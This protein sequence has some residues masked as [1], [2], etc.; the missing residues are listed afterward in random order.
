MKNLKP[1]LIEI[2]PGKKELSIDSF[3][4]YLRQN[5]VSLSKKWALSATG[6]SKGYN[7]IEIDDLTHSASKA[8]DA[9]LEIL[10]NN[11]FKPMSDYIEWL[12]RRRKHQG[13]TFTEIQQAFSNLRY[14]LSPIITNFY[15]QNPI[16]LTQVLDRV[17]KVIDLT[18]FRFSEYFQKSH[19]RELKKHANK[20]E[21][22]VKQRTKEL[23]ES[24][25]NYQILFEEISDGCFVN[26]DGRIVFANKAFCEMHGYKREELIGKMC[27]DLIAEDSREKV[28]AHF[29]KQLKG[30]LTEERY[31]YCRQSKKGDRFPTEN[32]VKL[33]EYN[34][35]P[36]V[37]GLCSDITQRLEMEEKIKQK[38]RL[39]L[40]GR[41]T[42]SI[43]H[44]IRNPLSAI[45]VNIQILLDKLK[46]EGNDLRR[47]QIASEQLIN[48]ENIITQVLDFAKP[49]KLN[50]SLCKIDELVNQV[51]ELL[52]G[53]I[54]E[55]KIT[56]IKN[57]DENLPDTIADKDKILQAIL[58]VLS[59]AIE[60]FDEKGSKKRITIAAKESSRHAK[61]YVK[62]TISDNGTGI[63]EDDLKSIFEPFFTKGKKGGVGLGLS[64][65]KKIIDAHHGYVSVKSKK[66]RGTK[67]H[68]LIPV[69]IS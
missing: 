54:R 65:V 7:E 17:S 19:Q 39:A 22:E 37:L 66:G 15:Q 61:K 59:N 35:K 44:E 24:R 52:D 11:D 2:T 31:V 8:Y 12:T 36:A 28:I 4:S 10:E 27:K 56:L 5:K 18:I 62:F 21:L 64:I 14:I 63:A 29:K 9:F 50:Y 42:T 41:L 43:A 40:I 38:D 13:I 6:I 34:G 49:L 55:K 69:E 46:L 48:L 25:K 23:E 33:I 57:L 16:L 30:N 60:S 45:K 32:K 67:F 1:Q 3:I 53:K 58:N 68:L 47:L 51:A 20:L 26:Q